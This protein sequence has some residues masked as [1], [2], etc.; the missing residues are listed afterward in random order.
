M[1]YMLFVPEE[2][3]RVFK[4]LSNRDKK[5]LEIINK[6]VNVII[7]NPFQFKPLRGDMKGARRVH[8]GSSFVL[9]YEI[10]EKNKTVRLLDY[11]HHDNIY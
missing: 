1:N 9:M 11:D 6:K 5:Q 3:D 10:D 7:K 8:I 2:L 4:K